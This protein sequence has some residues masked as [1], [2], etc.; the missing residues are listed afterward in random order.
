LLRLLLSLAPRHWADLD[1]GQLDNYYPKT[2]PLQASVLEPSVAT[3]GGVYKWQGHIQCRLMTCTYKEFHVQDKQ[4][5][6]P[7]PGT[8]WVHKI[9]HPLPE[10]THQCSHTKAWN[11]GGDQHSHQTIVVRVQPRASRG[12][13]DL[14]SPSE[15]GCFSAQPAFRLTFQHSQGV[16]MRQPK[17][18]HGYL[19]YICPRL[20]VN[21]NQ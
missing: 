7:I 1:S 4:L 6:A 19:P 9:S 13:T 2:A 21:W 8:A 18:S 20:A 16:N 14:L 17:W 5:Q 11:T 3:T 15:Y 10:R 12:I